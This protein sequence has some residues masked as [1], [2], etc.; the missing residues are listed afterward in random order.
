MIFFYV[1]C[2]VARTSNELIVD[3]IK[4]TGPNNEKTQTYNI[5]LVWMGKEKFSKHTNHKQ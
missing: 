4:K 1:F 5:Q 3:I 2:L